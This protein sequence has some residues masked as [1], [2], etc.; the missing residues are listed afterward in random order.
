MWRHALKNAGLPLAT[1]L[2]LQ[3]NR[4]LGATVV[5]EALFAAPGLGSLAVEATTQWDDPAIQGVVS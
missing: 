1:I 4:L 3:V 2:A 5:V